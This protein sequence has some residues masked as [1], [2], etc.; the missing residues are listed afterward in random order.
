M[1]LHTSL[2]A[3]TAALFA[4]GTLSAGEKKLMHCFAFTSISAATPADWKAFAKATDE[5]PSKSLGITHVWYG[6]LKKPLGTGEQSRDWGACFEFSGPDALASYVGA[7]AHKA[8]VSVY[9]K[10]RQPGTTT[11]DILGQ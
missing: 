10:V 4:A 7:P 1:R 8:W 6:K 2:L 3:I 5:L 9:E 11:F